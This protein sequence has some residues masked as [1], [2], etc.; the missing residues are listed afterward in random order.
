[1]PFYV[2]LLKCDDGSFY[3]GQINHVIRRLD[4][5]QRGEGSW[6]T[7]K[8]LPVSLLY[9]EVHPTRESAEKREMQ[10]KKW[11]KEKKT[12]LVLGKY[13]DLPKLAIAYRDLT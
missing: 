5:H 7:R 6:Y 1:M 13:D 4:E 12:A 11:R 3:V 8:R 10:I 9:Y 2:Y